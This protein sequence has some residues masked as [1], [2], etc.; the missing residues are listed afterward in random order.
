MADIA[1]DSGN[2]GNEQENVEDIA[3]SSG[4]E[5]SES[6]TRAQRLGVVHINE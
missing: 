4:N 3:N 5:A 1:G 2:V 6:I